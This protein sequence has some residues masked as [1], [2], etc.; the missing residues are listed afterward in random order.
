MPAVRTTLAAVHGIEHIYMGK[1]NKNTGKVIIGPDGLDP[2]GIKMVSGDMIGGKTANITALEEKATKEY[3]DNGIKRLSQGVSAP[4][5][6][7]TFLDMPLDT[8]RKV[9]G[10]EK[11]GTGWVMA[12]D[13]K[14]SI[15]IIIQAGDHK[16][17]HQYTAFANGQVIS[18]TE[19][20]GT[21]T[22][23][24]T[25][26][27]V[28]LTFDAINPIDTNSFIG[29]NGVQQIFKKFYDADDDF[30]FQKM[31]DEVFIGNA[32]NGGTPNDGNNTPLPITISVHYQDTDGQSIAD[33]PDVQLNGEAGDD[34][35]IKTP[36]INGYTYV[37]S[38]LPLKGK[39]TT[40][41]SAVVTYAKNKPNDG[42]SGTND[43]SARQQ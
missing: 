3:A 6:A 32:L 21:D 5:I 34:Y 17:H 28:T 31:M 4:E 13:N 12:S 37:K 1:I 20:H 40:S 18:P 15:G 43:G 7:L 27:D 33:A 25:N 9:L 24:K 23:N 2:T 16:G 35:E 41:Q 14:P 39:F 29:S 19:N 38:T 22:N 42:T 30:N 26:A 36:E 11:S 8:Y 10:Y